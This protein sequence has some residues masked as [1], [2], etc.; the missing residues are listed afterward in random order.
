MKCLT[1]LLLFFVLLLAACGQKG[2]LY[3]P[4]QTPGQQAAQ[5]TDNA[6]VAPAST[7]PAPAAELP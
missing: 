1:T 3:L 5:P 4:Q 6:T 7:P 2:A